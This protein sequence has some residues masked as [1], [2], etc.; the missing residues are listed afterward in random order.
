MSTHSITTQKVNFKVFRFNAGD[1]YLPYYEDYSMEVTSEEVVLDILNRIKWDLDGSFSYRRSCRHGICGACAIKVNGRATLACKESMSTIINI[2]GTDLTIEPLSI[3]RAV[4]D[5]IIDKGDFWEKHDAIHPFLISN[6]DEHPDM[7]CAVTPAQA[8]ELNDADLCIQCGACHYACPVV[9]INEDF[10]GPAAFAKAY[11]FE[12]DVRD[13]AH[14]TRLTELHEE[15]Q[16]LW[17]CVKCFE[18]AEACPKDVNPIDKITKLHQ[19]LFKEGVATSNV[20]TRHAVG[21]KHSIAKHGVLDEGGLVLYSEGPA[22]V[23]HIPVALKMLRKGKIV[24][25]WAIPKSDNLDE[26]QKLIKSSSTVKF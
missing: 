12:A 21:F 22:I 26:I 20:A 9:E 1:D 25:P 24:M 2:F 6:I 14:V 11:R 7:E 19:M 17:D 5:L 15:K 13:D 16:G 8:D 4:K 10:F 3:K 23:K 18:C